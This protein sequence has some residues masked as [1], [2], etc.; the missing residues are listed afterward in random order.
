L[1]PQ[2]LQEVHGRVHFS[3]VLTDRSITI[4]SM[5]QEKAT[6]TRILTAARERFHHRSYADVGVAE[7]CED[8]RIQKG[9]FYHFFRSKQDLAVAVIDDMAE[10]WAHG[11]LAEAFDRDKT[12]ME[13]LNAIAGAAYRWQNAAKEA[14]GC[15]PGCLFG[16]LALELSTRDEVLRA[17]LVAVFNQAKSQFYETLKEAVEAAAIAPLNLEATAGAMLSYLEGVIMLAK[18][19]NDPGL[20]LVLAPA[21]K[22]LRIELAG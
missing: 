11:F 16:N 4:K 17:R 2:A 5:S 22:T 9:S 21:I 19:H 18:A 10:D 14:E 8:A 6:R 3:L 13:R 7:I 15:M 1:H 20:I 12:P